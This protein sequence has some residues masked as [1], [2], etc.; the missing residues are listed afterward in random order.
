MNKQTNYN[1]YQT[2][3]YLNQILTDI[4]ILRKKVN[5]LKSLQEINDFFK[6]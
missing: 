1:E 6:I 3:S 2:L 4:I 5:T